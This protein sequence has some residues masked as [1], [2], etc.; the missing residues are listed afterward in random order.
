M[1]INENLPDILRWG[2]SGRF[3]NGESLYCKT[4]SLIMGQQVC[5]PVT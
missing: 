5:C 4:I 3:L 2:V 1:P